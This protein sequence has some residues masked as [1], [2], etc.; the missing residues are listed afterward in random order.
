MLSILFLF[1]LSCSMR[2]VYTRPVYRQH[3]FMLLNFT[4]IIWYVWPLTPLL[5]HQH[6]IPLR[7]TSTSKLQW[8]NIFLFVVRNLWCRHS[9]NHVCKIQ[10]IR[11]AKGRRAQFLSSHVL[12]LSTMTSCNW[13]SRYSCF[14][15]FFGERFS[16]LSARQTKKLSFFSANIYL[17]KRKS[18][19]TTEMS[20]SHFNDSLV[21]GCGNHGN[22]SSLC[23]T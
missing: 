22:A 20:V 4:W 18:W 2:A 19:T 11:H 21:F 3:A 5:E 9:L 14:V 7:S 13:I 12:Y 17:R 23:P 10:T 15:F 8:R 6:Y 16:R 1:L